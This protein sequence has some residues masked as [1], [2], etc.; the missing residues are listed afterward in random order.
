MSRSSAAIAAQSSEEISGCIVGIC[1]GGASKAT[2]A[3]RRSAT[4]AQAHL[5][6]HV[7]C[8][9]CR[10]QVD[11]DPG[12]QAER[13]GADLAVPEWASQLICSR[14]RSRRVDFVVTPRST[15]GLGDR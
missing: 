14:C 6:L 5:L 13:Y 10:H 11:L 12:E 2:P 4:T 7:W 15:G 8:K 1:D 3:R 9:D